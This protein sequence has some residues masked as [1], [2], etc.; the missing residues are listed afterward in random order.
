MILKYHQFKPL[1]DWDKLVHDLNLKH[2][3][4]QKGYSLKGPEIV[5]YP[6]DLF[7][8]IINKD[9]KFRMHFM[10]DEWLDCL[11]K[12]PIMILLHADKYDKHKFGENGH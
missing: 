12:S 5:L 7:R 9:I 3:S 1:P 6:E 10:K 8:W 11:K 4:L 2:S